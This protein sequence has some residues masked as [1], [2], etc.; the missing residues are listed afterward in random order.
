MRAGS[1][2]NTV[3]RVKDNGGSAGAIRR[4]MLECLVRLRM[5]FVGKRWSTT[6]KAQLWDEF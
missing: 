5:R 6:E 3:N 1:D 2:P 4:V